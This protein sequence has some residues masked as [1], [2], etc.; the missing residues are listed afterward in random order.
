MCRI[1]GRIHAR[2]VLLRRIEQPT[3]TQCMDLRHTWCNE[4]RAQGCAYCR[5]HM[6]IY[7]QRAEHHFGRREGMQ[8]IRQVI[9]N[10]FLALPAQLP[11]ETVAQTMFGRHD[12]N[13]GMRYNIA[14]MYFIRVAPTQHTMVFRAFWREMERNRPVALA[15]LAADAQNVHT[16]VVVQQT[17]A[18]ENKLLNIQVLPGQQTEAT[19]VQEWLRLFSSRIAWSTILK[20]LN[21]IHSW[22]GKSMCRQEGDNLYRRLL[23][24]AVAKVLQTEGDLQTELFRRLWEECSES[25]GLC[26]EGHISRLCNAFVGFDDSFHVLISVGEQLQERMAAI[27]ALDIPLDAKH[28]KAR[29]V[30]EELSIASEQQSAW[31]DAF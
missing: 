22:F 19:L 26:C 3:E 11:W 25:V 28:E 14:Y 30:F 17:Q 20:T 2:T 31:L 24:G 18:M 12:L 16:T 27:A 13:D 9:R 21:D 7:R 8:N 23:R 15:R 29:A 10:E 5:D 4:P 1:H 6:E